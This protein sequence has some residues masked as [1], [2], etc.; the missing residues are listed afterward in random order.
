MMKLVTLRLFWTIRIIFCIDACQCSVCSTTLV[1]QICRVQILSPHY[2]GMVFF[3]SK[4]FTH[5]TL[6][7]L[8]F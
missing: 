4:K 7:N 8:A 1:I 5:I 2:F 3:L 6:A